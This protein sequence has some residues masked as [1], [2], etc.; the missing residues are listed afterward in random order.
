MGKKNTYTSYKDFT[1]S[2]PCGRNISFGTVKDMDKY[3]NLHAKYCKFVLLQ[4]GAINDIQ[5]IIEN[6]PNEQIQPAKTPSPY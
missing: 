2:C 3:E 6:R 5:I 1:F 4:P